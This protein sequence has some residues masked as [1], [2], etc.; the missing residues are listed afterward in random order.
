MQSFNVDPLRESSKQSE[1]IV[2]VN[3]KVPTIFNPSSLLQEEITNKI[4]RKNSGRLIELLCILM[5]F[6]VVT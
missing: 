2:S 1:R 4:I 3:V 5:T 6:L